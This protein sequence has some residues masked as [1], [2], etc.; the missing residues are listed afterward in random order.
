M[1]MI[2]INLKRFRGYV[3]LACQLAWGQLGAQPCTVPFK[4]SPTTRLGVIEWSKFPEFTLPF[5]I[6]YGGPRF[7][8]TQQQPLK[9]GFSHLATFT[10][11]EFSTLP[12]QRR[13]LIH[14]G[15]AFLGGNTNQ[16][17]ELVESPWGNNLPL[18]QQKWRNEMRGFADQFA[19]T[20]GK[21]T[22]DADIFV[23]DIE[24]DRSTDLGILGLKT[25]PL[26]PNFYKNL[27]DGTF[28]TRYKR[29]MQK[30]Y[31][32][33]LKYYKS[34]GF[35]ASIKVSSY[36]DV[37]I[38][39]TFINIDG[40]TWSDWQRSTVRL[41]YIMQDTLTNGVGGGFYD[42]MNFLTPSAYFYYNYPSPFAG[43]YLAYLLFQIEANRAWSNKDMM[44]F[45][46]LRF[47]PC[48]GSFLQPIKPFMAE[49][50]AI[51]P[52]FSGAKGIW[53]WEQSF[54]STDSYAIYEQYIY[55]LYRLS[56]FKDMFE[57][58]YQLI[59]PKSARD[60][61]ADRD[62]IWRG[63]LKGNELL[64][65]AHNPFAS[66]TQTTDL[67]IS[68]GNWSTLVQLKGTEVFMCKFTLPNDLKNLLDLQL[69]PSPNT[70]LTNIKF[71]MKAP[72]EVDI[73]VFDMLGRLVFERRVQATSGENNYTYDLAALTS[74]FY[75]MQVN[76]G[77]SVQ[78]RKFLKQ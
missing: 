29:D 54:V 12:R 28:L 71:R 65:A 10:E 2:K 6:V 27:P 7:G 51:F 68:L 39:N 49:A 45:E 8:D 3:A 25:D 22:P 70:G 31:T 38:R 64:V 4:L 74:G 63:V 5:T 32:E 60:H 55:G 59:I 56:L 73:E 76:D 46:W 15:V 57:G 20:K 18:Y 43:G 21:A 66:E 48:C 53:L 42:Q 35:S 72:K 58:S 36:A 52:F 78:T 13:A 67:T 24:R 69:W 30:L 23:L 16:P 50:A 34:L 47:H 26:T 77:E 19:D 62:A 37:P 14:Y 61:F 1:K 11:G 44:V 40:N 75:L 9:H 41:N 33:P 17:W